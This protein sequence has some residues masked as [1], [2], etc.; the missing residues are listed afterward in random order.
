MSADMAP[1]WYDSDEDRWHEFDLPN[2]NK[3]VISVIAKK[4]WRANVAAHHLGNDMGYFLM[5][6]AKDWRVPTIIAKFA[7]IDTALE[8]AET[9]AAALHPAKEEQ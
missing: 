2:G 9:L 7:D 3:L 5:E 6:Y 1:D 4:H 8:F